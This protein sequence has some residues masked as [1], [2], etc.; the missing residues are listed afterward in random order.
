MKS[1]SSGEVATICDVTSRTVIRWI[2]TGKIKAFKLPGRGN[3]RIGES[4]LLQFL[5]HNNMP[6]PPHLA[7]EQDNVCVVVSEDQYLLKHVKRM[8]RNADFI[9]SAFANGIEAGFEIAFT[10][11]SLLVLD[12]DIEG[13]NPRYIKAHIER[14]MEYT[15]DVIVF[16]SDITLLSMQA[17]DAKISV[18]AKPFCLNQFAQTLDHKLHRFA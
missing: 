6:I 8:V 9:V 4:D 1:F 12:A 13:A 11:P 7:P 16:A 14:A 17:M 5:S 2:G 18:L 10:K 3:N 15:P